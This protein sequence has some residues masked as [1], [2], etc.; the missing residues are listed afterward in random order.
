MASAASLWIEAA[1]FTNAVYYTEILVQISTPSSQV[2]TKPR[3]HKRH[4][5]LTAFI[6][7]LSSAINSQPRYNPSTSRY[8]QAY[9]FFLLLLSELNP[10]IIIKLL[11]RTEEL[12]LYL[13]TYLTCKF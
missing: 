11:Q 7:I 3:D 2:Y 10:L 13:T 5:L 12:L 9:S 1:H 4:P 8:Q 6:Y